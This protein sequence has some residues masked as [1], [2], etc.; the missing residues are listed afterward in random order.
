MM[1]LYK[2]EYV[3]GIKIEDLDPVGYKVT[4]Y[5]DNPEIG[6]NI[7]ADL[8]D[9]EFI[10]FIKEELKNR[11]LHKTKYYKTIKLYPEQRNICK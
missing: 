6:L 9:E 3:G 5:L 2:V 8:P 7:I 1:E 10:P 4:F 11:K